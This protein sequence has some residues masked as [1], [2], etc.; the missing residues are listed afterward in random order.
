MSE[1]YPFPPKPQRVIYERNPLAKVI[2]QIRFPE[3]LSITAEKP[4]KFQDKI[5]DIY[6][7]YDVEKPSIVDD[8]PPDVSDMLARFRGGEVEP[9]YRFLTEDE[10]R[11]IALTS[12]F[13][14]LTDR[15]YLRWESFHD[16]FCLGK[17]ALE[18]IYKPAFYT[19][20][21]LRYQDV[22][23][24]NALGLA[25]RGWENLLNQRL[26]GL[27][28]LPELS[29]RP[30]EIKSV[31]VLD[32]GLEDVKGAQVI[33]RHGFLKTGDGDKYV[34]DAD[35]FT[36][37]RS[38]LDEISPVLY[39]FNGIAGDLFR[40]AISEELHDALGPKPVGDE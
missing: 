16:Q 28:G 38:S 18:A 24:L 13:V 20:I 37:E 17:H 9:I 6:P 36:E 26:I 12:E 19:R 40:W 32:L 31:A 5:R 14:A 7:L 29:A 34:I 30:L 15:D 3:I 22:I 27:L 2:C 39:R 23:D 4:A 1:I 8:L 21:G 10:K 25:D 33:L 11:F 35:F